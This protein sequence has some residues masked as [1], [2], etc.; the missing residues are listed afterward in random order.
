MS[1][2]EIRKVSLVL[3]R[4]LPPG[5]LVVSE[6]LHQL[7]TTDQEAI[8]TLDRSRV[9]VRAVEVGGGARG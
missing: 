9:I 7:L 6:D 5:T 1:R 4:N 2:Q 3:S 8:I